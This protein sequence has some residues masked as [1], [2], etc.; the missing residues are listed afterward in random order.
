[1][2]A[3][4]LWDELTN[5][6]FNTQATKLAQ[7]KKWLGVAEVSLW[8]A[9]DWNFKRVPVTNLTVTAGAASEPTDFGKA[10][11]LYNGDG[12]PMAYLSPDEFE[13]T[14]SVG[15][16]LPTGIGEAYTVINRQILVGPSNSGTYKLSYQRRYTHLADG[17][18]PTVGLMNSAND[19]PLW[20]SE[21]HYILVPWAMRLGEVLED[22]PTAATLETV[23][24]GLRTT[25]MFQAMKEE[26][27]G[28]GVIDEFQVW[29]PA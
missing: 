2:T 27:A 12:Q 25:S 19:T 5:L 6:R 7:V 24:E 4:E 23:I 1:M 10:R 13:A 16:T 26:L 21:H 11:R 20:D 18:T 28:E 9:A 17:S 3:Q 15:A 14:Y 29:A 8:N 22:D